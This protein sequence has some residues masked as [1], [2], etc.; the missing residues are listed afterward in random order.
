VQ[1]LKDFYTNQ[2]GFDGKNIQFIKDAIKLET[3]D[4]ATLYG[5]TGTGTVNGKNVNG[6]FIG[7][8]ETENNTYF[9]ATNNERDHQASGSIAAEITKSILHDKDIY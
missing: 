3:K 8:V 5:K 7:Y 9:F 6:W 1:T 2:F 4:S